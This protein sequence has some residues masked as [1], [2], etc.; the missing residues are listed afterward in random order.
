M[1]RGFVVYCLTVLVAVAAAYAVELYLPF[2]PMLGSWTLVPWLIDIGLY[3]L[4]GGI[5]WVALA[6]FRLLSRMGLLS[7]LAILPH[8][9]PELTGKT[10]PAYPHI[11]LLFIIPDLL[12][13][14]LGAVI[15]ALITSKKMKR[16][17]TSGVSRL[18]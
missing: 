16:R 18:D 4:L 1:K 2:R 15:A 5:A 3:A 13:I 10:D 11:G 12:W 7:L 8:L 9:L 6:S 14:A 17:P